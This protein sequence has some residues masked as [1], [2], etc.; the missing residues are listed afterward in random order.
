VDVEGA[1]WRWGYVSEEI[2]PSM[3]MVG[4]A[5]LK[6]LRE[7]GSSLVSLAKVDIYNKI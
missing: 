4:T 6:K 5:F 1:E 7:E 2:G 3:L